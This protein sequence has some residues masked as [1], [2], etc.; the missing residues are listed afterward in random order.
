MKEVGYDLT[1]HASKALSEIPDIDYDL[2]VT[3]GCGDECPYGAPR[4]GR[5]GRT[6]IP[7]IWKRRS[8]RMYGISSGTRLARW[9]SGAGES[10]PRGRPNSAT[11]HP[12]AR[13]PLHRSIKGMITRRT[14]A[15]KRS[16]QVVN[17]HSEPLCNTM[18]PL[19]RPVQRFPRR[20]PPTPA[21]CLRIQQPFFDQEAADGV[22][23]PALL[24]IGE[25]ERP[26]AA[27]PSA[28]RAIISRD[29]PTIGARSILLI[30]SRSER[31]MP[32]PPLR[33]ILSPAATSIT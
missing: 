7:S 30:T 16:L 4:P 22:Q 24:Q 15:R 29:A 11:G 18:T 32:G 20:R 25:H 26:V 2:A 3:M 31:V 21:S 17:E 12:A 13:E 9:S 5:T 23:P 10:K 14:G 8:L 27:H 33:G 6:R 1:A 19:Q 28:S